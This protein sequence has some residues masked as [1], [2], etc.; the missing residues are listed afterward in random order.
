MGV[1]AAVDDDVA[2]EEVEEGDGVEEGE[3]VEELSFEVL[4]GI[5]LAVIEPLVADADVK[6]TVGLVN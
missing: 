1:A 6:V 3:D 4:D 5:W 2:V